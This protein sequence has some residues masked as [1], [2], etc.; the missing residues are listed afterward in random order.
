VAAIRANANA[1]GGVDVDVYRQDVRVALPAL[2]AA[3]QRFDLAFLDP[4]YAGDLYEPVLAALSALP[5]PGGL[6]VAEH[7]HK[8][9]LPETIGRLGRTRTVR[10]GEH[11]LTF[12]RRDEECG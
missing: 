1:L 6:A 8:R 3:G 11:C 7:F 5:A 2:G 12:Y 10:V 4:P 9:A